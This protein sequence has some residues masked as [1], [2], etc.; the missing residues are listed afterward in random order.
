[1]YAQK[2]RWR[3]LLRFVAQDNTD[4]SIF[5]LRFSRKLAVK[6]SIYLRAYSQQR[7]RP[8]AP[9]PPATCIDLTLRLGG[10]GEHVGSESRPEWEPASESTIAEAAST[11]L[12]RKGP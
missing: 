8:K 2:S 5:P 7:A 3:K 4:F 11:D 6:N 1:M 9:A 12:R 10:S